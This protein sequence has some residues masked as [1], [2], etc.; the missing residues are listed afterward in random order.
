MM[1]FWY[2]SAFAV[3]VSLSMGMGELHAQPVPGIGPI[4]PSPAFSP[5]LN[6]LR[7]NGTSSTLNYFGLVRPQQQ[8]NQAILGLGYDQMQQRQANDQ[9]GAGLSATGHPTQF[10]NYGGYFLSNSGL[11]GSGTGSAG[12]QTGGAMRTG[13][14][15]PPSGAAGGGGVPR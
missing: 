6:L 13:G 1:R 3:V 4:G 11:G 10:L 12:P 14:A 2:G 7:N 9:S 15:T 8:T 5:Y